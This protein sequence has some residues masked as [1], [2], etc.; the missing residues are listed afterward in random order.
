MS[1]QPN[2][3]HL[4]VQILRSIEEFKQW[5]LQRPKSKEV[6]LLLHGTPIEEMETTTMHDFMVSLQKHI[7]E[8]LISDEED[9]CPLNGILITTNQCLNCNIEWTQSASPFFITIEKNID[10][11]IDSVQKAIISFLE[12]H[13][14]SRK[15]CGVCNKDL[16]VINEYLFAPKILCV[17]LAHLDVPLNL[18]KS[19]VV[20]GMEYDCIA[21]IYKRNNVLYSTRLSSTNEW[22]Y[23]DP[24]I[25]ELLQ[26]DDI[27]F[28]FF[29]Q[30]PSYLHDL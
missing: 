2:G 9:G 14:C 29:R 26:S 8:A 15:Q 4:L 7:N 19:I 18:G 25:G 12:A 10:I 3:I 24:S 6:D 30:K 13:Y 23:S 22:I 17:E 28:T 20:N 1:E 21:A 11:Q 16:M 5:L 27:Q